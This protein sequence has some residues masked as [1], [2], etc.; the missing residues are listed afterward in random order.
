MASATTSRRLYEK[1]DTA[2]R[3]AKDELEWHDARDNP[4]L[5]SLKKTALRQRRW[6]LVLR[7]VFAVAALAGLSWLG[8]HAYH[9]SR[10]EACL[11]RG[12]IS[13]VQGHKVATYGSAKLGS[14][15][16]KDAYVL[17]TEALEQFRAS[18]RFRPNS[19]EAHFMTVKA[20]QQVLR[21]LSAHFG[22]ERTPPDLVQQLHAQIEKAEAA[23]R[24]L[25]PTGLERRKQQSQLDNRLNT[26]Q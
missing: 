16:N 17:F 22:S 4:A 11:Q 21:H 3:K 1:A 10:A 25:D 26:T 5:M 2:R 23:C 19:L 14:A 9:R 6:N 13:Y 20:G 7:G 15:D 8:W 18:T 24:K 12:M